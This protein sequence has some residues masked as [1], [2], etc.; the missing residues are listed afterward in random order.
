MRNVR[1]EPVYL[2]GWGS[3]KHEPARPARPVPLD[4]PQAFEF[5][6]TETHRPDA[7]TDRPGDRGEA[8]PAGSRPVVRPARQR[9]QHLRG[10]RG[11]PEQP[12]ISE[13]P[14]RRELAPR[15][16]QRFKAGRRPL[17][18]DQAEVHQF[19]DRPLPRPLGDH[20]A[21][22]PA[23]HAAGDP[24]VP[25]P[26]GAQTTENLRPDRAQACQF[27]RSQVWCSVQSRAPTSPPSVSHGRWGVFNAP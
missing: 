4:D 15:H 22:G 13:P 17:V 7:A 8:L 5:L 11:H 21:A 24:P 9:Q 16:D 27:G 25:R 6:Q 18:A 1:G 26:P 3:T 12:V 10:P 20:Q 23:A 2:I 14:D 19:G